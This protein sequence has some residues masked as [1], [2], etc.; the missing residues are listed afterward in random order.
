MYTKAQL[1]ERSIALWKAQ[2]GP[3]REKIGR[4]VKTQSGKLTQT[5]PPFFIDYTQRDCLY[6]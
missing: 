1:V 4:H 3:I 5:L 6:T 2:N